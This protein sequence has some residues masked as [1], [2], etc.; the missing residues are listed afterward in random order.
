MERKSLHTSILG[1]TEVKD[2]CVLPLWS[3]DCRTIQDYMIW[4]VVQRLPG[5]LPE[6]F[7]DAAMVLNQAELGVSTTSPRWIRCISKTES[8]F[9][10]VT[11]ALF[12]DKTFPPESKKKV[13][14]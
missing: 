12:V 6:T 5:Y 8:A 14:L 1:I 2:P 7:V 9:G 4:H 11:S 13:M 10:F 3:V